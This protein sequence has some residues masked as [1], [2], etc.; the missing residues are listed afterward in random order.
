MEVMQLILELQEV[1]NRARVKLKF[2][3]SLLIMSLDLVGHLEFVFLSKEESFNI[4]DL[5]FD[6]KVTSVQ[7]I[8]WCDEKKGK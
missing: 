6:A 3:S 7:Q 2:C 1:I 8:S 4:S 5:L